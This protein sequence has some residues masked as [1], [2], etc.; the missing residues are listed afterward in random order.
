MLGHELYQAQIKLQLHQHTAA[1]TAGRTRHS[2]L[3]SVPSH[4]GNRRV[5]H[6]LHICRHRPQDD[7]GAYGR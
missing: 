6:I 2:Q 4:G 1:R 3:R 5:A 7:S